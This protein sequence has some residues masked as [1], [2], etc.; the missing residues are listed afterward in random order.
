MVC[1]RTRL[2]NLPTLV[3][4]LYAETCRTL[5]ARRSSKVE[6]KPMTVDRLSPAALLELRNALRPAFSRSRFVDLVARVDRNLDDMTAPADDYPTSIWRVLGEANAQLWWRDLLREARFA[7]PGD[8]A[9]QQLGERYGLS[10]IV[11]ST[12]GPITGHELE[13]KIK[14]AQSTFNIGVWR[15]R[16]GAIEGQVCRIEFPAGTARGTGFL[17]GPDRILTNQHVMAAVQQGTYPPGKVAARFD[18]LVETDG[19]EVHAG[20]PYALADDWLIDYSPPS[21]QDLLA[22]PT[23]DP[24]PT[25]LDYAILRLAVRAGEEPVGGP[26]N[27]PNPVL[28]GW[29]EAPTTEYPFDPQSALS[30]VQHPDGDPM[31]VALDTEGVLGRNGN[32]TRVRYTTT[33]QPGSSGSP[34]FSPDWELIALHHSGDPKYAS[35]GRA[36][37]NQGIP[38][39]AIQT[40]VATRNPSLSG[41]FGPDPV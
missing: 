28:R 2:A 33:T 8:A 14:A 27:D 16:L 41:V 32:G 12:T 26:T 34:C 7:V 31:Q 25:E 22:A 17:I 30:I 11:A 29:V 15:S 6:R 38:I 24:D 5:L 37:F 9:L 35:L 20:T 39:T 23:A 40:L 18:Y 13:L 36:E 10:A 21:A 3:A 19:I 1:V 4:T